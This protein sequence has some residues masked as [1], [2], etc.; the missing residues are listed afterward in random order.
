MTD[1][2]TETQ[3][4]STNTAKPAKDP[5]RAWTMRIMALS[6]ILLVFY[7][8]SDRVTPMSSQ[9]RVH[10]LVVPVAAEVSGAVT[11]VLVSNNQAVSAGDILFRIDPT[12]YELA[13]RSAEASLESSRQ[14]TGASLASVTVA[15]TGVKS[16]EANL[17]RATSDSVRLRRIKV[18]DPGALSD[19]KM[20]TTEASLK[21]AQQQLIAAKANLEQA[22]QN[23]GREGEDNSRIQQ[24]LATLNQAQV[25]LGKTEVI[26]PTDG[27][28][29]DVRV[30]RG[31]FA[32]AGVPQMTF[33]STSNIWVQAD[34]TENNLGQVD[35]A[36]VAGIVFD[37]YPGRVFKATVRE[38]GFGVSVDSA[39]LGT[40]PTI[41]NNRQ[42]LRD[43]QRFP[44]VIDFEMDKEEM[45]RLR[46]G[47]QASVIIYST[48][49][50]IFNA[51][52][53]LY[54]RVSS[55][56]SYAY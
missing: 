27:V 20:E 13:V 34:F 15:E 40:L 18:Q 23:L 14:A 11:D 6:L 46:V 26:A 7:L 44:V 22:R 48:D 5:V 19:R 3:K 29:T 56:L 38:M 37:V 51:L 55:L 31:N 53:R 17:E 25:N 24:S 4:E 42:W 33:I 10:A 28:V 16:A 21:V 1:E 54:L 52:G 35:R 9:A 50:G 32:G 43:A 8:I 47:A 41:Q 39:P 45:R 30:D 2:T 49:S 12:Q 36:D